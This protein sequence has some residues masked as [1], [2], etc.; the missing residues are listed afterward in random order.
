MRQAL[1]GHLHQA[2][3]LPQISQNTLRPVCSARLFGSARFGTPA[4]AGAL[5]VGQNINDIG[6]IEIA[7]ALHNLIAGRAGGRIDRQG[8]TDKLR[9]H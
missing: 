6:Q 2:L 8:G 9:V 5:S 7:N 3:A 1:A 4:L